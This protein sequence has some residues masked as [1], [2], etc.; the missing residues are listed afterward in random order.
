MPTKEELINTKIGKT[1]AKKRKIAGFT[2]EE[3]AEHLGI[4]NEAFSRIERGL[5]SPGIFKLY[6]MADMFECGVETF[7]IEGSRRPTDQVEYMTK[8][9]SNVPTTDRQLI[10][11]MVEK[12]ARR[13]A[14]K[15]SKAQQKEEFEG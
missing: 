5:V 14:R 4:G 3:V 6:E 1:V 11:G 12:L 15:D 13:F 8:L 2:Q 7:L 10:I 9:L